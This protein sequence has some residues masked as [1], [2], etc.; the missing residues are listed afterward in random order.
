M[1]IYEYRCAD[2]RRRV[3]LFHRSFA[4]AEGDPTCPRCGGT[5]LR[6]IISRVAVV[7]S[8]ESR[9]DNLADP[10]MLGDLDENDPKSLARWMRKMSGEVGEEM[11]PEFD[12]VIDRLESGQT[13]EE[14]EDSMPELG[15]DLGGG[16]GDFD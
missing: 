4:A 15:D 7:R 8:E 6:R 13:P 5:Q 11:P 2:C 14:I 16:L 9:L 10:S 12:E 3:S 1:P